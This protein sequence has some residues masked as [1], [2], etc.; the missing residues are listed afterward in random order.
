MKRTQLPA[1]V[2]YA[3]IAFL[4]ANLIWG[5]AGP[6]IKYTLGF[7][8]INTFLF[9]RFL[10]VGIILFPYIAIELK[11]HK[12]DHRDYFNLFL[13]GVFSQTSI[14]I[15]FWAFKLTN[16]L[17]VTI[18]GALGTIL[19]VYA[20]HY[21]YREK[22]DRRI[23]IGLALS[24]L[25]TFIVILEPILNPSESVLSASQRILGN[26]LALLYNITWVIYVI[27]SKMSMGDKSAPLKK[28]LKFM[29]L[30]PMVSNYP[31]S[32]ISA[33]TFYIGLATLIPFALHENL[34][35]INTVD[36]G[37]I[38][39]RGLFGLIYMALFSSIVAYMLNQWALHKGSVTDSAVWTY[40]GTIFAFP[41]AYTLLGEIP[42][43]YMILGGVVIA[44]GVLIAE[45]RNT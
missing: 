21:F 31:P 6:V 5:A 8:P 32:L 23:E 27:W 19:T 11:K 38:D 1:T 15:V 25:G 35:G 26:I 24:I 3:Q 13:L 43:T 17:D 41:V 39:S 18:I 10:I 12:I 36:L 33:I 14:L 28:T 29:H 20:A 37:N 16:A 9:L 34:L 45:T 2:L 7:I 40:I 4:I 30:R 22:V 42:N 44:I